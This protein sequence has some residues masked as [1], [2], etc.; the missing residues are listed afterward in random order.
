VGCALAAKLSCIQP[1]DSLRL[2]SSGR[3]AAPPH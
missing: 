3:A 1:L 2:T